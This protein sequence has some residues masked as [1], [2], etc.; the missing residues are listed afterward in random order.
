ML[1]L[2]IKDFLYFRRNTRLFAVL[3]VMY[4]IMGVSMNSVGAMS[5]MVSM[6]GLIF[7]LNSFSTDEAAHWDEY[8]LTLPVSRRD[9]VRARYLVGLILMALCLGLVALSAVVLCA[10]SSDL[11]LSEELGS[12]LFTPMLMLLV[13]AATMPLCYKY[14]IEKGRMVMM[15]IMMVLFLGIFGGAAL[16]R[17]SAPVQTPG[18]TLPPVVLPI[19]IAISLALYYLSYRVSVH[20]YT[21]REF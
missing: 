17:N 9:A 15:A 12:A 5:G 21:R 11:T 8:G 16:L 18:A 6:L 10:L 20:V 14:G 13:S 4:I 7:V 1:G 2:I 19:A 3:V